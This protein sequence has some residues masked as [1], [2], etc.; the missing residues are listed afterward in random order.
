MIACDVVVGTD[1]RAQEVL[2]R[3]KTCVVANLAEIP[4]GD[5][6]LNRDASI[7]VP[8]RL[9]LLGE[10]TSPELVT[11]VDANRIAE[12]LMGHSVYSN[13]FLLGYAW[14]RGL[15][16]V[17]LESLERAIELN[18]V[19]VEKNLQALSWGAGYRRESGCDR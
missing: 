9:G 2:H 11:T 3:D 1:A 8:E 4:S 14:Q 5:L 10:A 15:V 6:V 7:Q 18:A 17:S 12:A 19:S 16:P 13:V